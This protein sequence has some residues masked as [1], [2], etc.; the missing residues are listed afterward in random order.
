FDDADGRRRL[1]RND[2]DDLA[3]VLRATRERFASYPEDIVRGVLVYQQNSSLVMEARSFETV[4]ARA[5]VIELPYEHDGQQFKIFSPRIV[6]VPRGFEANEVLAEF[7]D[8]VAEHPWGAS[9]WAK[10]YQSR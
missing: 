9:E 4:Q 7:L 1:E 3:D 10:H 2:E 5:L 6:E 8:G